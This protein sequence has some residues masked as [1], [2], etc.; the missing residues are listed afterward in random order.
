MK[1]SFTLD[2]EHGVLRH[3]EHLLNTK[4]FC[5]VCVAE[6]AGQVRQQQWLN[7]L[8]FL[9]ASNALVSWVNSENWK[10]I[11]YSLD[12][13]YCKNQMQLMLQEM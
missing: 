5:V 4:G 3:L 6:G 1:V 11:L 12:R 8:S 10:C 2:G 13:I 9:T 7:S